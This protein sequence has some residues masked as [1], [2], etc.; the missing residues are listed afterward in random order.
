M[1]CTCC[2]NEA[3]KSGML[4]FISIIVFLTASF[5]VMIAGVT[6]VVTPYDFEN[7][8]YFATTQCTPVNVTVVKM[9]LCDV[10]RSEYGTGYYD[11]WIAIWKCLETGASLVENPFAGNGQQSIAMN[12]MNDFPLGV[13]QNISCNTLNLPVQYPG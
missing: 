3:S 2:G 4:G 7:L 13:L 6:I 1:S 5:A 11:E 10:I 12:S 8:P 9:P